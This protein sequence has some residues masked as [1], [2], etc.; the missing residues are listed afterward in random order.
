MGDPAFIYKLGIEQFLTITGSVAC[1]L[2]LRGKERFQ[3]EWKQVVANTTALCMG[4]AMMVWMTA[5]SR[6]FGS[7]SSSPGSSP[8]PSSPTTCSR[9]ADL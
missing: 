1:E 7:T 6:A 3:K 9:R 2:K 8:C 4:N 5:P